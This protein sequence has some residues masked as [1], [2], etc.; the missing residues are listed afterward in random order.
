MSGESPAA[1]QSS[2]AAATTGE[3]TAAV[4]AGIGADVKALDRRLVD[5]IAAE[6]VRQDLVAKGLEERLAKLNELRT[7]VITDRSEYVRRDANDAEVRAYRQRIEALER[8]AT[9]AGVI[10]AGA[11]LIAGIVGAAIMRALLG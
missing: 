3:Q 11:V 7:E 5:Y 2:S 1:D 10:G 8:F 9:R 6:Q 4:L